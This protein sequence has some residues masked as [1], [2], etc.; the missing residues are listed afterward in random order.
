MNLTDDIEN[1]MTLRVITK[2]PE[3]D[4][5]PNS[6]ANEI[7]DD[8]CVLDIVINKVTP[9]STTRRNMMT[10]SKSPYIRPIK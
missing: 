10:K 6:A 4:T 2:K 8:K 5:L 3:K 1:T 9:L 7:E